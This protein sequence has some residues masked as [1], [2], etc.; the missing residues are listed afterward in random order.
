[1]A[2]SGPSWHWLLA[3]LMLSLPQG[4]E[5][6]SPRGYAEFLPELSTNESQVYRWVGQILYNETDWKVTPKERRSDCPPLQEGEPVAHAFCDGELHP[7]WPHTTDAVYQCWYYFDKF[8]GAKRVMFTSIPNMPGSLLGK[9]AALNITIMRGMP[10]PACAND[11]VFR[12]Q[13]GTS[14]SG[15]HNDEPGSNFISVESANSFRGHFLRHLAHHKLK[16]RF[17]RAPPS[18]EPH[19]MR[20]VRIG[21]VNRRGSR[22]LLNPEMVYEAFLQ[23]SRRTEVHTV[24]DMADLGS[25]EN[26][27]LFFNQ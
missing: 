5:G 26:Q 20:Q 12:R 7:H 17:S 19:A 14:R 1:M 11:V 4:F 16:P 6:S 13:P 10:E 15:W 21:I 25:V 2:R 18:G 3:G 8:P 22:R 23:H 9:M 24:D 27:C